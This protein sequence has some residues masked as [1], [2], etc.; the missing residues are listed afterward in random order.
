MFTYLDTK[1]L[2]FLTAKDFESKKYFEKQHLYQITKGEFLTY[3]MNEFDRYQ[4]VEKRKLRNQLF[5]ECQ[6][7][8]DEEIIEFLRKL[9]LTDQ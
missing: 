3:I 6:T 9:C 4:Q 8:K 2:G 5:E 1:K 7:M